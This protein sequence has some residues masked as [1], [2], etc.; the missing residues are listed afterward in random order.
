MTTKI[1]EGTKHYPADLFEPAS[2]ADTVSDIV[3]RPE[4][5]FWQDAW[6]GLRK[7]KAAI[8]GLC[9]IIFVILLAIFGPFMNSHGYDEQNIARTNLPPK[10]PVLEHL[11]FLGLNGVDGRGVDQYEKRV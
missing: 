5:S 4:Q 11:P 9:I 8:V 10:V 2:Q 3:H 1:T 6:R 7:N